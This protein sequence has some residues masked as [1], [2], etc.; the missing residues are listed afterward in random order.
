MPIINVSQNENEDEIITVHMN[1]KSWLG[2]FCCEKV[3]SSKLGKK[4][5]YMY[6]SYRHDNVLSSWQD[7]FGKKG[8]PLKKVKVDKRKASVFETSLKR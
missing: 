6:S 2:K 8:L 5:K 1:P 3:F 4:R 7:F